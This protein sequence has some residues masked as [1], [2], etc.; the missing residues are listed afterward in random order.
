MSCSYLKYY[1]YGNEM[2]CTK[3]PE[4]K[5]CGGCEENDDLTRLSYELNC[6]AFNSKKEWQEWY[7]EQINK[8]KK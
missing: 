3:H 5:S 6:G 2:L 1:G 4:R 7:D 8:L